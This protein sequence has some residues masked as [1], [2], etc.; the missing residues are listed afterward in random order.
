MKKLVLNL[1]LTILFVCSFSSA[2]AGSFEDQ[3]IEQSYA[4]F[5]SRGNYSEW[6]INDK[7]NWL[8]I[9]LPISTSEDKVQIHELLDTKEEPLIDTYLSKRFCVEGHPEAISIHYLLQEMWGDEFVWTLDQRAQQTILIETY[10]P[11]QVW[12][13][14]HYEIPSSK[15][16]QPEEALHIART[17]LQEAGLIEAND[18]SE[19]SIRYGVHRKYL[20]EMPCHYVVDF[21]E[22]RTVEGKER[23]VPTFSCYIT[24]EGEIMDSSYNRN[25]VYDEIYP[26]PFPQLPYHPFSSWTLEEKA[27]FSEHFF[28]EMSEYM[29]ENPNYRGIYYFATRY[30][31]G[32]PEGESIDQEKAEQ[33]ARE[34]ALSI[35]AD[36]EYLVRAG[37]RFFF[38]VTTTEQPL[39]KVYFSTLFSEN[40]CYGDS[41]GYFVIIDAQ[42]GTVID[43]YEHTENSKYELFY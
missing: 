34:A 33:L 10:L 36:E 12:D 18:S 6:S 41:I 37:T 42:A 4:L 3:C 21:R 5:G 25:I 31:Y 40:T 39:W 28:S 32:L 19:T 16:I 7:R 11:N 2:Y 27:V 14:Y 26:S 1:L 13:T 30:Y 9:L 22:L 35:G 8:Q 20:A 23:M 43:K 38:D 29:E 24:N 15:V 17:A